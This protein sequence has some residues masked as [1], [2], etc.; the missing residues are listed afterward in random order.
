[1]TSVTG[2]ILMKKVRCQSFEGIYE[3]IRE[4]LIEVTGRYLIEI[5]LFI[6]F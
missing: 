5:R 6:D 3:C 4:N 1:M 2:V